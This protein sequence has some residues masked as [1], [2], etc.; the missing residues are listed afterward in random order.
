MNEDVAGVA[1]DRTGEKADNEADYVLEVEKRTSR[2]LQS[3]VQ[4]YEVMIVAN[5]VLQT[6]GLSS[7]E[8]V[9]G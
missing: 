2:S 1:V 8:C 6:G 7:Y 4:A 9:K 5:C 3:N